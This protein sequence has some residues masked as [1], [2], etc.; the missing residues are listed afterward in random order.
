MPLSTQVEKHKQKV[1]LLVNVKQ[2][3]EP[4]SFRDK[5]NGHQQSGTM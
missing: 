2:L 3:G 1:P 4:K 5:N